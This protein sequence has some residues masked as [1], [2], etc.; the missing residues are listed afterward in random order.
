M[1]ASTL[2]RPG[3][4]LRT[5]VAA[6]AMASALA[7]APAVPATAASGSDS[8]AGRW[9]QADLPAGAA[10]LTGV[11]RL[12]AAT[13]WVTGFRLVEDEGGGLDFLPVVYAKND[14]AGGL[15]TEIPTAPGETG[16]I[17]AITSTSKR[18]AW[19]VGDQR[20]TDM[21]A[22]IMT[23]HWNGR[24]WT[25]A[26][27]PTAPNSIGGG[28]LGVSAVS[29]RDVWAAGWLQIQDR[30]IPDPDGGPTEIVSHNEGFVSHWD[31]RSW[32]RVA[33]PQ[34]YPGWAL[35]SISAS[36]PNDVWA[37]GNGFGE[38]DKPLAMHYDGSEWTVMPTPPFGGL[39]GEFNSVVANSPTDVWAVGR[40]LLDEKD[41]GHALVMHWNG[42]SWTRIDTPE[43][44]GPMRGVAS[45]PGGVV[46]VGRT[47]DRANG[48]ALRVVG[49]RAVSLGMP[50]GLPDGKSHSPWAVDVDRRTG[51]ATVVGITENPAQPFADP[52]VLT[53]R[54]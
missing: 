17:N 9:A 25:V 1:T 24:S 51:R 14:R 20:G 3:R 6:S 47:A 16:R 10:S 45:A 48:Y 50:T 12:D 38:D 23:Q 31:G 19:L 30:V 39:Y 28:L 43:E 29:P 15:W 8:G 5:L 44:A 37:V 32:K 7:V 52:M 46:V 53:G 18:D 21:G 36:G 33:L 26:D 2:V 11:T 54:V 40:T 41:R 35:N 22:P 13:T 34:P 27:V 4:R 42:R 49:N